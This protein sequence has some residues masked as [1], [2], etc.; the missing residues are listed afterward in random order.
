MGGNKF[1]WG[2][3]G[4]GHFP[5]QSGPTNCTR[6]VAPR[7]LSEFARALGRA[8][9]VGQL[10]SHCTW[11]MCRLVRPLNRTPYPH[12]LPP[13][14]TPTGMPSLPVSPVNWQSPTGDR[15]TGRYSHHHICTVDRKIDRGEASKQDNAKPNRDP[16]RE[17]VG[18]DRVPDTKALKVKRTMNTGRGK[19]V[20]VRKGN[21]KR[22]VQ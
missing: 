2:C 12:I 14:K 21:C 3:P 22:G 19:S 6:F 9:P 4:V 18:R 16:S 10:S 5:I 17:S 8:T 7:G 15:D 1:V 20:E 13:V 11:C